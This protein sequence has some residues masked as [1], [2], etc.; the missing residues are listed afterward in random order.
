[1]PRSDTPQ[2]NSLWRFVH[3]VS[4]VA[5]IGMTAA[6]AAVF[7]GNLGSGGEGILFGTVGVVS[8]EAPDPLRHVDIVNNE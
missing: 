8:Q 1:M 2:S 5:Q 4:I 6:S 3:L 7:S